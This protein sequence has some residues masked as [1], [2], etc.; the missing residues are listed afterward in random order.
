MLQSGSPVSS[1]VGGLEVHQADSSSGLAGLHAV[2]L[3]SLMIL[4]V[5]ID[6]ALI[7]AS[8][9]VQ[10]QTAHVRSEDM[11]RE[12]ALTQQPQRCAITE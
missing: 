5:R 8:S 2:E 4:K 10:R 7:L 12:A 6:L 11:G 9:A 1:S 3:G